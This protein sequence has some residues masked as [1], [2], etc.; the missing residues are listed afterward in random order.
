[1]KVF[2]CGIVAFFLLLLHSVSTARAQEEISCDGPLQED[3]LRY[4]ETRVFPRAFR[5]FAAVPASVVGWDD[6][7][8]L[9]FGAVA[10]PTL[11]LMWP[12]NPSGDTSIQR[13]IVDHH[14]KELD[15]ALLHIGTIPI[16]GGIIAY[17]G[18]LFGT[19]WATHN[20]KLFEFG[21]LS[22]EALMAVQFM[23]VTAKLLLGR[24]SPYQNIDGPYHGPTK[25]SF[26]GGTPSGHAATVYALLTVAGEYWDKAPL[27]VLAH[28]GGIY[29][30][31]SLVYYNQHFLSDVVWGAAMGYFTAKWLVRHR[32][33]KYRCRRKESPSWRDHVLVM[34]VP[35]NHGFALTF[36]YMR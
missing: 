20:D 25:F 28:V 14:S 23:H 3:S 9:R 12:G 7:D 31:L 35:S 21:T 32:S 16:T 11:A 24:E 13:Y 6:K 15:S 33:S 19:A 4:P 18:L 34:P 29:F 2:R 36:A 27:K 26:P 17:G 1:M 8:W 5:D 22:L 30:S 10:L